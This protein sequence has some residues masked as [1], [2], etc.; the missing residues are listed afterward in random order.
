MEIKSAS[1]R[2]GNEIYK[3]ELTVRSHVLHADEPEENGGKDLG[4]GPG[5]FLRMSLAACTAITLRM[6]AN[7]KNFDVQQI[8]VNVSTEAVDGKTIFRRDIEIKGSIDE[9]QQERMVQIANMCPV[10]KMLTN[11][12]EIETLLNS[13][14]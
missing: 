10:H 6:Y 4:P 5:D 13:V 14:V 1:A 3:T 12:I 11:P 2:I 8:D 9:Q 7:R